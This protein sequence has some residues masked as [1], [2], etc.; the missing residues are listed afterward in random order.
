MLL[1]CW[2][3]VG[4]GSKTYTPTGNFGRNSQSN[5]NAED[6]PIIGTILI[7]N[8]SK[9]SDKSDLSCLGCLV[10]ARFGWKTHVSFWHV[11]AT[12]SLPGR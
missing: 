1:L 5:G 11:D 6:L 3:V 2:N 4:K 12:H 10:T 7:K 9:M 8:S